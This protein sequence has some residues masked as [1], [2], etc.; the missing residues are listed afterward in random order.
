MNRWYIHAAALNW[1]LTGMNISVAISNA[2]AGHSGFVL[3]AC[4]AAAFTTFLALHNQS[5]LLP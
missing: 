1:V 4:G 3:V 5:R 2:A